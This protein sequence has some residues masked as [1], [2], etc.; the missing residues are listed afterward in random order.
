MGAP[1]RNPEPHS[2]WCPD[3][4]SLP[5]IVLTREIFVGWPGTK[6]LALLAEALGFF[7]AVRPACY[8]SIKSDSAHYHKLSGCDARHVL[9]DDRLVE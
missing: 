4:D 8:I 5:E 9:R 3:S 2:V 1:G 7:G 6:S